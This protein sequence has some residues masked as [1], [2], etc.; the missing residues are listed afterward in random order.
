MKKNYHE[1]LHKA[2]EAYQKATKEYHQIKVQAEKARR[3]M[4]VT[5]QS[6]SHYYNIVHNCWRG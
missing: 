1:E 5:G 4:E 3:K 6:F 2:F